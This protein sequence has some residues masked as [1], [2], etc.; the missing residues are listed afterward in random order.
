MCR[1]S[2]ENLRKFRVNLVEKDGITDLLLDNGIRAMLIGCRKLE[3]LDI[4]FWHGGLTDAGLE[5][6][7]KYGRNLRFL[8]LTHIGNSNAGLV[9]LSEGC[10]KLRKLK[11]T[12]CPFS[13][14]AVTSSVFSI[15]SLRYAWFDN[16]IC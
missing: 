12:G 3:R 14:Q 11:L 4:R 8:S 9:K 2:F 7:G 1:N 10:P 15:P 13:E 5:Y 6:I 16:I